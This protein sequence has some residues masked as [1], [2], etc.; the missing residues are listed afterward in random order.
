MLRERLQN[1]HITGY[2]WVF[3]QTAFHMINKLQ[4]ALQATLLG[5]DERAAPC[6]AVT[7]HTLVGSQGARHYLLATPGGTTGT[8]GDRRALVIILHG[9][10]ASARQALGMAFP[11]SPLSV[12]LEI[13]ERDGV[14]VAA[15]DAGKGGWNGCLV[16][17][18]Q[19]ASKDDVAFIGALIDEAIARHYADPA[20]VYVIGVSKGGL[21]AYR[22]ALELTGRLAAFSAVLASMPL[23]GRFTMPETPLSALIFGCTADPMMRYA[24]GKFFY[25]PL[26]PVSSIEDSAA[27]WHVHAGLPETPAVHAIPR[28]DPKA[29]THATRYLWGEGGEAGDGLQVGLYKIEHAGH[30]E[31]SARKRYPRLINWV[32]GVQNGDFEV[33]EAAWEFFRHKRAGRTC[34]VEHTL[35]V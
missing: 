35:M 21:M 10:G 12:W 6:A 16:S 8:T 30:A 15:P 33:A 13:A 24:G 1:Y 7:A 9:A 14:L 18:A 23:P 26:D 27:I 2:H 31:P 25:S 29:R 19:V 32:T 5:T 34:A 20:R 22:L 11:P 28:R 3:Q 4:F 17:S